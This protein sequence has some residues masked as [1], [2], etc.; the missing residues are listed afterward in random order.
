MGALRRFASLA[1]MCAGE[2]RG[3]CAPVPSRNQYSAIRPRSHE[4]FDACGSDPDGYGT[5]ASVA[6]GKTSGEIDQRTSFAAERIESCSTSTFARPIRLGG[7]SAEVAALLGDSVSE[8]FSVAPVSAHLRQEAGVPPS[9]SEEFRLPAP[10]TLPLYATEPIRGWLMATIILLGL[11]ALPLAMLGR[12]Q[13]EEHAFELAAAS[14]HAMRDATQTP[15]AAALAGPAQISPAAVSPGAGAAP[16][17]VGRDEIAA[18]D[19][20][21]PPGSNE[22]ARIERR[23]AASVGAAPSRNEKPAGATSPLRASGKP[24]DF[25]RRGDVHRRAHSKWQLIRHCW[26]V[27]QLVERSSTSTPSCVRSLDTSSGLTAAF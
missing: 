12:W 14:P 10:G 9:F 3:D 20:Q 22:R 24:L 25:D 13:P 6:P 16:A 21:N 26:S 27:G 1:R 5:S 4:R 18:K 8:S 19:S 17:L 11:M 15:N 2:G 7:V 23:A